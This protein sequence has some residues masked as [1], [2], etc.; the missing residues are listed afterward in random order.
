MTASDTTR[1][2]L[3]GN[4]TALG[5]LLSTPQIQPYFG[6][7]LNLCP[8]VITRVTRR[9]QRRDES[10]GE[11]LLL[12]VMEVTHR[13]DQ[14]CPPKQSSWMMGIR[15]LCCSCFFSSYFFNRKL[16]QGGQL[17]Q[18]LNSLRFKTNKILRGC[19]S[20]LKVRPHP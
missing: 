13:R 6:S 7:H 18:H 8:I 12:E 15:N 10:G 5:N 16:L 17:V 2:R 4:R 11:S 14:G 1:N 9:S 3:S 19:R 20:W